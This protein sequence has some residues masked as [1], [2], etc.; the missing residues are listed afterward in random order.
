M[1]K[2][3]LKALKIA[4]AIIEVEENNKLKCYKRYE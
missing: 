4:E 2:Q 3:A 1:S